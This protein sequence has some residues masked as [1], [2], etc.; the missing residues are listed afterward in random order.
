[1]KTEGRISSA[2][3]FN[4]VGLLPVFKKNLY[5]YQKLFRTFANYMKE[6]GYVPTQAPNVLNSPHNFSQH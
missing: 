4:F 5:I 3:P 1:M 6:P 2:M